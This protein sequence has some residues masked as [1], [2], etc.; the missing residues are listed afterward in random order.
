MDARVQAGQGGQLDQSPM[1]GMASHHGVLNTY[2]VYAGW[3]AADRGY[4]VHIGDGVEG[5]G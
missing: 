4:S 1:L 3:L 5:G 2:S